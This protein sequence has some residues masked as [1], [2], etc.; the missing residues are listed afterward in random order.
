MNQ[1]VQNLNQW[2][3]MAV[4]NTDGKRKKKK[5]DGDLDSLYLV[6]MKISK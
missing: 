1:E 6:R 3:I 4:I 5:K 2:N